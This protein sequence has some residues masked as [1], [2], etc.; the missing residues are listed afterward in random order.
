MLRRLLI[1]C[2]IAGV[3][4]P[5]VSLRLSAQDTNSVDSNHGLSTKMD[6]FRGARLGIFIHW[7]IYAVDGVS[8]SWS[9]YNKRVPHNTYMKQIERFTASKYDP[10]QWVNLIKESGAKYAVLTSKHHDG[11][12]LWDTKQNNLSIP[13]GS[14][15]K[16]DV[17]SPFYKE[18]RKAGIKAGMYYSLIDWTHEDYPGFLSDQNKYNM[19]DNPEKWNKFL[20]FNSNQI[21]ELLSL[22]NPDLWWFDGDWEHSAEEW[23][24]AEIRERIL[25]HNPSAIINGR[26]AGYGDYDTPE[27]NI[28]ISSPNKAWELC[29]T[30]N[31]SW[32][33]QPDDLEYKTPE[34]LI[35]ILAEITGKGGNL[36]LDIGP[37]EDGTIPEE[38]INI[39][40]EIG[41]WTKKHD[42]AIFYTNAGIPDGHFY[43][44]TSLSADSTTL[45]LFTDDRSDLLIKGLVNNIKR[46]TVLGTSIEIPVKVVGKISWSKVPGL[47]FMEIPAIAQDRYYTVLKL[48]LDNKIKLYRGKGGFQ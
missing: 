26:L 23:K 35:S 48:E 44:P 32:G 24:A 6:W 25:A 13:K 43:G 42:E 14:P 28:P 4:N 7:G 46:A 9:F 18:L 47:V 36:L 15:A 29:L 34:E 1:I 3:F 41:Y 2:L 40:K 45:Y 19:V 33:Y 31:T 11:V 10:T 16:R 30:S 12:A 20:R 8:E 37:R 38:Q 21:D 5:V 17:L 22:I 39:L 27:Q